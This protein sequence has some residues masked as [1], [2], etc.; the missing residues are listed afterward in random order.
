MRLALLVLGAALVLQGSGA[1]ATIESASA[2]HH[3]HVP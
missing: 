2:V 1:G 3:H